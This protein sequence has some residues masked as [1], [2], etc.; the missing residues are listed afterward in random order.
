[1]RVHDSQAYRNR[2]KTR[3]KTKEVGKLGW[4]MS[5]TFRLECLRYTIATFGPE[6]P[7]YAITI[8]LGCPGLEDWLGYLAVPELQT[9]IRR[10][11]VA[12]GK[13]CF[14]VLFL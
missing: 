1:M 7:R 13:E 9:K 4:F 10:S 14:V 5:K 8:R 2:H 6:C 3:E 11:D 12:V